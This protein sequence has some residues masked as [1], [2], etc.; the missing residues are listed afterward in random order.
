MSLGTKIAIMNHGVI[1]QSDTPKNIYNKPQNVFVADFIGSPPMNLTEG[2]LTKE[3]NNFYFVPNE[4][5]ET[6]KIPLKNYDFVKPINEN[7]KEVLFGIRPEHI[8]HKK[9]N[10]ND[11][12]VKMKSE[13]NEYIGHEQIVTFN[14]F[15]QEIFGKFSSTIEMGTNKEVN[16]HFDLTQV[17]LFDKNT[18]QRI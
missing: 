9:I 14:Y 12:E 16:L 15:N 13:L 1:Q 3:G 17:S 11:F 8:F 4:A 10:E 6:N 2:K 7:N 5:N 18:S